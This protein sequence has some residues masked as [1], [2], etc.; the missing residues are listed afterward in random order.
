MKDET[1]NKVAILALRLRDQVLYS[2]KDLGRSLK[3]R[4]PHQNGAKMMYDSLAYESWISN[5][6]SRSWDFAFAFISYW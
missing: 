2:H 4:P 6:K 1:Y 5:L 3:P